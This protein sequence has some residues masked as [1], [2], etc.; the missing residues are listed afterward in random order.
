MKKIISTI[1]LLTIIFSCRKEKVEKYIPNKNSIKVNETGLI[2]KKTSASQEL[3]FYNKVDDLGIGLLKP[4]NKLIVYEDAMFTKKINE[5]VFNPESV[6][7]IFFKPDYNI[8]YLTCSEIQKGYI[9]LNNGKKKYLK[10]DDF[11]FIKWEDFLKSVQGINNSN[12]K[13]N[14]IKKDPSTSSQNI[15]ID[16][17]SD[18]IVDKVQGD[19]IQIKNGENKK[20]WIKWKFNNDLLIEIYLL[21]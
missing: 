14:P 18:F 16:I 8:F 4:N 19:W 3:T 21:M 20:G 2:T 1:I 13:S 12:W 9:T 15:E 10:L 11:S 6:K 5:N 7:P 17:D